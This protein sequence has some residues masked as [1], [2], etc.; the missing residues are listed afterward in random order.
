MLE[1]NQ[2][3]LGD[4]LELLPHVPSSSVDLILCGLPYGKTQN[5]WDSVIPLEPL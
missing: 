2:V 1:E 3:H 5:T 4:C